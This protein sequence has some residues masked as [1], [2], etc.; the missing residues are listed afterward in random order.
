MA[1][2]IIGSARIDENG[3]L[4]GG[5]TGDQKQASA[6][7]YKGEVSLQNFY[8]HKKGWYVFRP[9]NQDV[10]KKIGAAMMAACNNFNIGYDQGNRLDIIKKGVR[11]GSKAECDCSS[12]VRAC[13]IDGAGRDVGNFTTS[14]EAAVLTASGLFE[15]KK[16]YKNGMSLAVGDILVTKSK[17]HTVIVVDSN[18]IKEDSHTSE[19]FPKYIGG[20]SSIV[21]ALTS[22]KINASKENRKKIAAAN[23]ILDYSGTANQ[24]LFLLALLEKGILKRP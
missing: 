19:Y 17:G 6:P 8:V 16:Q 20:S 11:T 5:K 22:L 9:K 24:N 18:Y 14:N 23:G 13:I 1:K 12:L 3:K 2:V 10:A 4:S 21:D 7:D 15:P